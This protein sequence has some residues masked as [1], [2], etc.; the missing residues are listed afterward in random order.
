MSNEGSAPQ[1]QT[2]VVGETRNVAVSFAAKLDSNEL[3]TGT[4]TVVEV[5][6]SDLTI[7]NAVVSTAELTILSETVAIGQAVTFTVS[8][9]LASGGL[10]TPPSKAGL[11]QIKVTPLTN[12]TNAQTFVLSTY[13]RGVP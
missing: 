8:G 5:T 4:P 10:T 1:I 11:Y 12:A 9:A 3:L 2:I 6:S 13:M 7:T